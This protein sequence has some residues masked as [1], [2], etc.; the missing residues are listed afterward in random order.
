MS[1]QPFG[2]LEG[3]KTEFQNS[4]QA[5]LIHSNDWYFSELEEK[6][7]TWLK[8][9]LYAESILFGLSKIDTG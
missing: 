2:Y 8:T 1:H 3:S 7:N 9:Y 4:K 5:T 6:L